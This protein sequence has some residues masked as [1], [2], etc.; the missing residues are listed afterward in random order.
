MGERDGGPPGAGD[1]ARRIRARGR[2]QGVGFRWHTRLEARS[3]GVVGWVRNLEDGDVEAWVQGH[4]AAVHGLQDWMSRGPAGA[5]VEALSA[6]DV[7]PDP[8]LPSFEIRR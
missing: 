8:D 2:V 1:I 3:L 5:R 4:A 7:V 6:E